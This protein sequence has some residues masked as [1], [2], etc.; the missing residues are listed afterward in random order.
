[1]HGI[2]KLFTALSE[3]KKLRVLLIGLHNRINDDA[4]DAIII[5]MKKKFN[6]FEHGF[7]PN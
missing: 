3:D 5:V 1:M 6:I 4:C 2:I 7:Q